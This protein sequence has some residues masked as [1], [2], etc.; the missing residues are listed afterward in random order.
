MGGAAAFF[1][2]GTSNHQTDFFSADGPNE[3]HAIGLNDVTSLQFSGALSL[4]PLAGAPSPWTLSLGSWLLAQDRPA[5]LSAI[6]VT[7]ARS[8]PGGAGLLAEFEVEGDPRVGEFAV[9]SL[10][11]AAGVG[12][13][14]ADD[15]L[16][17]DGAGVEAGAVGG[18]DQDLAVG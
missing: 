18:L 8:D 13:G 10:A 3:T 17:C 14:A 1:G 2:A 5:G 4:G 9:A 7:D 16:A 11:S 12:A 6:A 15:C